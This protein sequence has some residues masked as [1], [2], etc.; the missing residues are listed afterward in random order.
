MN[1]PEDIQLVIHLVNGPLFVHAEQ[2]S[3]NHMA[4]WLLK[5]MDLNGVAIFKNPE[6]QIQTAIRGAAI[7]GFGFERISFDPEIA[8]LH[9]RRL[10]AETEYMEQ[11]LKTIKNQ[12]SGDEW[13]DNGY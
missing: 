1:Q 2:E 12:R 6:G 8:S 9:K 11:N 5:I 13:K 10:I 3:Q 4:E 7:L